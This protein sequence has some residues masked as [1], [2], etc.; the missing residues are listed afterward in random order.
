MKLSDYK[1]EQALDLLADII[2]PSSKI[3]ADKAVKG[4][5]ETGDKINGI[6]V[7]IKNHKH[8]I[9]EI[10][11]ALDG[12]SVEKY[13]CNVLTLPAKVLEI[14]NDTALTSFFNSQRLTEQNPVSVAVTGTTTET[15]TT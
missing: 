14:L 3:F 8:E 10:L 11:A 13:E 1:N 2:E 15:G 5:F 9:I 7:A 4:A 12:V 6:K